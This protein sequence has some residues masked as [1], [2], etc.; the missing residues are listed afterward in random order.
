MLY[1]GSTEVH[2]KAGKKW[3]DRYY[4]PRRDHWSRCAARR[5][6]RPNCAW[7]AGDKQ[8]TNSV[9]VTADATQTLTK[10]YTTVFSAR[11]AP[12]AR[13]TWP[14][15]K[16]FL[17]QSSDGGTGL[18]HLG[19]REYDPVIGQFL[20]VDPV[21]QA[22]DPTEPERLQLRRPEPCHLPPTRPA[23]RS[24]PAPTPASTT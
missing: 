7:L 16:G 9:A 24:A 13:G 17:G 3:A 8:G 18:T 14:D 12:A 10:R 11:A 5:A 20:S 15:D 19:A 1:V 2:L 4:W 23:P 6:A 22:G 21:L